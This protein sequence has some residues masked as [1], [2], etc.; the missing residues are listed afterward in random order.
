MLGKDGKV[1]FEETFDKHYINIAENFSG[2][3]SYNVALENV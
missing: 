2:I 3:E 1:V